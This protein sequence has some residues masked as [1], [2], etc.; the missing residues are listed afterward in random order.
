M[1]VVPGDV[2]F[3]PAE[4]VDHCKHEEDVYE[5]AGWYCPFSHSWQIASAM[6]VPG[7]RFSPALHMLQ[8]MH[9]ALP[10]FDGG[11]AFIGSGNEPY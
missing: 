1:V 6:A 9:I 4:H 5:F 2:Y 8:S 11:N 7:T 3:S 10:S